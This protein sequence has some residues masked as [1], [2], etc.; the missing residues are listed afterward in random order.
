MLVNTALHKLFFTKK[1][2]RKVCFAINQSHLRTSLLFEKENRII[3][4]ILDGVCIILEKLE[5]IYSH[6]L[7][8]GSENCTH[9]A[10]YTS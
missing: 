1:N 6:R 8:S 7:D 4:G 3:S 10:L 2:N 9:L 5:L